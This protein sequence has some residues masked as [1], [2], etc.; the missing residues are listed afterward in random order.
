[1]I[2]S[3]QRLAGLASLGAVSLVAGCAAQPDTT[4]PSRDLVAV[5]E[6]Q[7]GPSACALAS[8]AMVVNALRRSEGRPM[9][10]QRALLEG[11]GEPH[12]T[13]RLVGNGEGMTFAEFQALLRHALDFNGFRNADIR[14]FQPRDGG[15]QDLAAM[16]A[17]L[18]GGGIVVAGF[19]QGVLT[20]DI[21]VGHLSPLGAYDDRAARVIVLDVDRQVLGPYWVND[22]QLLEA[23]A[24]SDP[25][26]PSGN[27]LVRV[28][29]APPRLSGPGGPQR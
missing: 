17:F 23:M 14:V 9:L 13:R 4:A 3:L 16:R 27:G 21:H 29:L 19:D 8:A 5:Y 6:P 10:S 1:M 24:A 20:G 15:P 12:W 2:A 28:T 11:I 25:D 18:A 26:D 7:A 22:T